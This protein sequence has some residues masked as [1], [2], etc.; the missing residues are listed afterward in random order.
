MNWLPKIVVSRTLDKVESANTRVIND[1]VADELAR[2]KQ[3]PGN[4]IVI[5]GSSNLT[6]SVLEMGLIDELRIMVSPDRSRRG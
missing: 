4:D 1:G 3:Q 2:L 6:V 5:M